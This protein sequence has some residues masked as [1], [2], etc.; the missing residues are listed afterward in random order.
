MLKIPEGTKI[1]QILQEV[2][3]LC[4]VNG[5][6]YEAEDKRKHNEGRSVIIPTDPFSASADYCRWTGRRHEFVTDDHAF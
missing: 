3:F 1:K 4:H 6:A 5:I 2:H